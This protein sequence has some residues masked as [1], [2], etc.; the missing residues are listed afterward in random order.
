LKQFEGLIESYKK[1]VTLTLRESKQGAERNVTLKDC[2]PLIKRLGNLKIGVLILPEVGM[3]GTVDDELPPW[4][5]FVDNDVHRDFDV[6]LA[7]YEIA[8]LNIFS[9]NGPCV[10]SE[11]DP[12]VRSLMFNLVVPSI[13][14]CTVEYIESQG[15]KYAAGPSYNSRSVWLW[16]EKVGDKLLDHVEVL[17]D[18]C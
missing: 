9:N 17:L 8:D 14:H 11:L 18:V 4:V 1:I 2:W 16:E 12:K 7:I 10:A 15:Y 13:P 5:K 6:R 3:P